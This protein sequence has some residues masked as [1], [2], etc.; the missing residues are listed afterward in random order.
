[1]TEDGVH[2]EVELTDGRVLEKR[3]TASLG[4]LQRPLTDEQLSAKF[5]DQATLVLTAEQAEH[6][7]ELSWRIDELADVAELVD[8]TIP[9]G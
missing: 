7:L 9:D 3:L 5:R 8:A 1:M 4:N 6:A 2:V